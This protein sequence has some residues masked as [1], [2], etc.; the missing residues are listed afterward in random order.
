VSAAILAIALC[1][2][3]PKLADS[4]LAVASGETVFR[5]RILD[6]TQIRRLIAFSFAADV[7]IQRFNESR[8]R[9]PS[10]K[11]ED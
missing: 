10:V 5:V 1:S 4:L 11:S 3:Y 6:T 8:Q 9:S 2:F 7:T